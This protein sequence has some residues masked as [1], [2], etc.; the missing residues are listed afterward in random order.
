M[1]DPGTLLLAAAVGYLAGSISFARLVGRIT[2]PGADLLEATLAYDGAGHDP[3]ASS[4][5]S[6]T[7]VA[8]RAGRGWA[9]LVV[10]LDIA[11]AALPTLVF[12]LLA[13]DTD[14]RLVV[15]AAAVVGHVWPVWH[16]FVGGY[17]ISPI[18]GGLL[19]I[20]PLAIV[21]TI[22][23]GGVLGLVLADRLVAYDGWTVLLVPWF[24]L[25]RGDP[26]AAL[27]AAIVVAI[28]WYAMR[29][30]VGD[31][32]RRVRRGGRSWRERLGDIRA[33]YVG[34]PTDRDGP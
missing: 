29:A 30:E 3:V 31:H 24:A 1:T 18:L 9:L 26:A 23:A 25:V 7:N 32:L 21:V 2:A 8:V 12:A 4:G 10:V 22:L 33:G 20:D 34:R 11:K 28:Y 19:V 16:G 5:V 13:P 14:A 27:W 17:G 6:A 15:A